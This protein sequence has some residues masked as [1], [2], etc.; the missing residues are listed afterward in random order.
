[1]ISGLVD[2]KIFTTEDEFEIGVFVRE[3]RGRGDGEKAGIGR[4]DALDMRKIIGV[5]GG[6]LESATGQEEIGKGVE[7]MRLRKEAALVVTT[8]WPRVREV[9]VEGL[10]A[11]AWEVDFERVHGLGAENANIGK[12]EA[13]DA[14]VEFADAAR[15]AVDADVTDA[16]VCRGACEEKATATAT[17]VDFQWRIRRHKGVEFKRRVSGGRDEKGGIHK[18]HQ[19]TRQAARTQPL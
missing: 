2:G 7:E 6:D 1:M 9:D 13:D 19:C 12:A 3:A 18:A 17:E 11:L 14:G 16:G 8:L 5:V 10:D 4:K 15:H